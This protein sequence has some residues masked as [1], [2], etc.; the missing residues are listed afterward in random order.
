MAEE[1]VRKE[2][3]DE[4]ALPMGERFLGLEKRME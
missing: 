3:F 2:H 1:F 4:F